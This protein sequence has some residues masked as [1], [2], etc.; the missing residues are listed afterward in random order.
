MKWLN[1]YIHSHSCKHEWVLFSR[2]FMY[3][4]DLIGR[5]KV[6]PNKY[7]WTYKCSK[8]GKK[9]KLMSV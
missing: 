8:C 2:S 9:H 4:R 3:E 7:I 6:V 5:T 1:N